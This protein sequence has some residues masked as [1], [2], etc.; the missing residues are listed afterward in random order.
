M[1]LHRALPV[2]ILV[3][4]H[5][6]AIAGGPTDQVAPSTRVDSPTHSIDPKA[7]G[8]IERGIA[9]AKQ[10]QT[11]EV[12]SR[13][14]LEGPNAAEHAQGTDT[15]ARWRFDFRGAQDGQPFAR[16]AIESL[17]D[18]TVTRRVTYDGKIARSVTDADRSFMTG[19]LQQVGDQS[20]T[21]PGWFVDNR[22]G[23]AP[24]GGSP[25]DMA[26]PPLVAARVL[27][28]E[29][30]DGVMCDIVTS[31]RARMMPEFTGPDGS[32]LPARE[33]RIVEKVAY[34]RTDGLAR[35]ASMAVELEGVPPDELTGVSTFTEVKANL[36]FDD[37]AF[38]TSAIAGFA[39]K[40]PP[41]QRQ[42]DGGGLK[43]AVGAAAPAFALKDIDGREVTLASLKGRVVLL[44]FW[45]TWC[46]PC[47]AAMPAIQKIHEVYA[48]RPVTVLGVDVWE[49]KQDAGPTYFR[50][51]GFTYGCLL[52]GEQLAGAYGVTAIPTLVVID[53]SGQV[54]LIETGF[55]PEGEK[56]L[57]AAIDAALAK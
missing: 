44:D 2:L 26:L 33:M 21:M 25:D 31:V 41:I 32:K 12:I 43:V 3:A 24:A 9:A 53:K 20:T 11:L 5:I 49:R 6:P 34:A 16:V 22:L 23:L 42:R 50:E 18:G 35:R 7:R 28:E 29:E 46:G 38:D 14:T 39:K 30:L 8:I 47:K 48:D 57:R 55:G 27:G 19:T 37:S 1:S 54:G 36:K 45:A 10:L 17:K 51:K 40:E 15:P 56:T 13:T 4:L 52:E